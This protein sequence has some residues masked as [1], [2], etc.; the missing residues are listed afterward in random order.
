MEDQSKGLRGCPTPRCCITTCIIIC[1]DYGPGPIQG[2]KI[3]K[4][5]KLIINCFLK[6]GSQKIQSAHCVQ[7]FLVGAGIALNKRVSALQ[8][9][10]GKGESEHTRKQM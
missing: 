5:E 3:N 8:I 9:L 4:A 6:K 7:D 1:A 10:S 2:H